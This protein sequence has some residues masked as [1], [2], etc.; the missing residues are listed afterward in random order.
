VSCVF[1]SAHTPPA[2]PKLSSSAKTP[3]IVVGERLVYPVP[4]TLLRPI[5]IPC[6]L[7]VACM[8][9][10]L[11][12]CTHRGYFP[13]HED[14]IR[15]YRGHPFHLD[16]SKARSRSI[17]QA[18]HTSF[19]NIQQ[20]QPGLPPPASARQQQPAA[21]HFPV[22]VLDPT[23][24][25]PSPAVAA[26]DSSTP[27]LSYI[28]S[29]IHASPVSVGKYYPSNYERRKTEQRQHTMSTPPSSL[30]VT[31]L[32]S[33]SQGPT[34]RSG[35]S[36]RQSRNESE[37]KRKFQQHQ[38]DMIVQTTLACNSGNAAALDVESSHDMDFPSMNLEPS[39][40]RLAPFESPGPVTPMELDNNDNSYLGAFPAALEDS[41]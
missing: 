10:T 39:K 35:S 3:V 15:I 2:N 17:Q 5:V 41:T 36:V 7:H 21:L 1:P 6:C 18:S 8:Q 4:G 24:L 23:L 11:H 26:G 33:E 27:V 31:S 40:P 29:G 19:A 34:Y 22:T 13:L 30:M 20:H 38:R 12:S 9:L 25:V 14:Q 32:N 16:T 37:A 28:P